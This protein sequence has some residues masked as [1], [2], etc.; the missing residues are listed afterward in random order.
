[1]L[2]RERTNALDHLQ[3]ELE[4]RQQKIWPSEELQKTQIELKQKLEM[5]NHEM[6][7]K[8]EEIEQLQK[9]LYEKHKDLE[10]KNNELDR[11]E[12]E[13]QRMI[14]NV[15]RRQDEFDALQKR[16]EERNDENEILKD[17]LGSKIH[18]LSCM[19]QQFDEKFDGTMPFQKKIE[20]LQEQIK[21]KDEELESRRGE[22]E[23]IDREMRANNA[24]VNWFKAD[25]EK[26]QEECRLLSEG[27][28]KRDHEIK[29]QLHASQTV[30]AEKNKIEDRI[31]IELDQIK[32]ELRVREEEVRHERQRR[33]KQ[34]D[35]INLLQG[36]KSR[37]N[38]YF[39]AMK[40]HNPT[41]IIITDQNN[42]IV[43]LNK[44]AEE[45]FG[46]K[47]TKV[48]G[49]NIFNLTIVK[50]ERVRDGIKQCLSSGESVIVKSIS[51]KDWQGSTRLTDISHIP[52]LD[53]AGDIQG[54]VMVFNDVTKTTEMQAE[55]EKKQEDLEVM[56]QKF[57]EMQTRSQ[58]VDSE[59][60][61]TAMEKV[62]SNLEKRQ[63]DLDEI[64][65]SIKTKSMELGNITTKLSSR[66]ALEEI[67]ADLRSSG[68]EE[69][70]SMWKG[71]IEMYDEIDKVLTHDETPLKTKKLNDEDL[72]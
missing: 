12:K 30:S 5:R 19:K 59:R 1:M 41:P 43:M 11:E 14:K 4:E 38:F 24:T 57:H 72:K 68:D 51:V 27:L 46:I 66:S 49:T 47:D 52:M 16:F 17:E 32:N 61:A 53:I 8:N 50:K 39:Q 62:D 37:L 55:L 6:I 56:N 7:K 40:T 28:E 54:A 44:K 64:T 2:L 21:L 35:E 58:L 70:T 9:K 10:S 33:E 42:N 23:K 3:A 48:I 26:K 20:A 22:L 63:R 65:E 13:M 69:M 15:Q 18:E 60:N 34:A 31:K 45:I 36:E 25:I 67:E 71:K 29:K